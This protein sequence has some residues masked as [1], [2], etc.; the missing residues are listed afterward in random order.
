MLLPLVPLLLTGE[1][2]DLS[3]TQYSFFLVYMKLFTCT[4]WEKTHWAKTA[5]CRL[6]WRYPQ[7]HPSSCHTLQRA[8]CV[9]TRLVVP[10]VAC[11]LKA[12]LQPRQKQV[13]MAKSPSGQWQQPSSPQSRGGKCSKTLQPTNQQVCSPGLAIRQGWTAGEGEGEKNCPI[14]AQQPSPAAL[15]YEMPTMPVP[16]CTPVNKNTHSKKSKKVQLLDT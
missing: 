7:A 13:A 15:A 14:M 16:A 5:H 4:H 11:T 1:Y 12:R 2:P 8:L 3:G 10:Q 6:P 9:A